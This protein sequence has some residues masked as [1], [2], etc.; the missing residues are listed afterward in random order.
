MWMPQPKLTAS[1]DKVSKT[2][3]PKFDVKIQPTSKV[4]NIDSGNSSTFARII[5]VKITGL[6]EFV[7][8]YDTYAK[9]NPY[10][11]VKNI[12]C[13]DKNLDC[14]IESG[15][16]LNTDILKDL[17]GD[18]YTFK[19]KISGKK[20][21]FLTETVGKLTVEYEYHH[22]LN[23]NNL[24]VLRY[25]L[26]EQYRQRMI[27]LMPKRIDQQDLS[28]SFPIPAI[29]QTEIVNNKQKYIYDSKEVSELEYLQSGC[30]NINP[31][32][33]KDSDALNY[34]FK[35]CGAD[36]Q[37]KLVTK[38][39]NTTDEPSL[40][41][42]IQTPIEQVINNIT[43]LYKNRSQYSASD[44]NNQL[45][46]YQYFKDDNYLYNPSEN[47]HDA[48]SKDNT[49]CQMFTSEKQYISYP[50]VAEAT[51]GRFF[52]FKQQ[53]YI[54]GEVEGIFYTDVDRWSKDFDIALKLE[55]DFF[56]ALQDAK[57]DEDITDLTPYQEAYNSAQRER[58]KIQNYKSECERKS[59]LVN[60][61]KYYF[62]PELTFYYEQE[63]FDTELNKKNKVVEKVPMKVSYQA[64]KYWPNE[65]DKTPILTKSSTKKG[66]NRKII[67]YPGYS[68]DS[69]AYD[70]T[71]Q[72]QIGYKQTLYYIPSEKYFSLIPNG[73]Y[74]TNVNQYDATN[75]LDVGYVF[76]VKL[77]TYKGEYTT[78]FTVNHLGH[79]MQ[80]PKIKPKSISN[81]Q[82]VLNQYLLE[83]K[84]ILNIADQDKKIDG[85][86]F[87]NKCIYKDKEILYKRDCAT[88]E[89]DNKFEVQYYSKIVSNENL[90]PNEGVGDRTTGAKW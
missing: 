76:N 80:S 54:L 35:S 9:T 10:F 47:D 26:T 66:Q 55:K 52:V 69:F 2:D 18:E 34:Y 15:I 68:E 88:C 72:Y 57:N 90:F 49:Y 73:K 19:V 23:S 24:A 53:P 33:L 79:L 17:N 58:Q 64:E 8:N 71:E 42:I 27:V 87:V 67:S 89:D 46:K 7:D 40:S 16:T 45:K 22:V 59:D 63:Y 5:E 74:V 28:I 1:L 6:K 82:A 60:K 4:E 86:E 81:L 75:L 30:C 84:N 13:E 61:W 11:K 12:Y 62:E 44:F 50:S 48:I 25:H 70:T 51:S 3:I 20:A 85:S 77:T 39:D 37:I 78:W 32:Y 41:Y 83:N 38:C 36:S 31:A 65:S 21:N 29:C 14:K 56:K 43:N